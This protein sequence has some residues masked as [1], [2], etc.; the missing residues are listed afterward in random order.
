MHQKIIAA[1]RSSAEIKWLRATCYADAV[2]LL[3]SA[4]EIIADLSEKL[5]PPEFLAE[6]QNMPA[7]MKYFIQ[8]KQLFEAFHQRL[9]TYNNK[10]LDDTII[11][12]YIKMQDAFHSLER[13][14][15]RQLLSN[16]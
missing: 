8:L 10:E 16:P 13:D 3:N 5:N 7:H 2:L 14:Y 12:L 11:E 1:E 15:L 6:N 9:Q 4:E